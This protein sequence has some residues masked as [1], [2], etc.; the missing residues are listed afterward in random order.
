M[1]EEVDAVSHL[2]RMDWELI[3]HLPENLDVVDIVHEGGEASFVIIVPSVPR[4]HE[5]PDVF[6][7]GGT[8][9]L[10]KGLFIFASISSRAVDPTAI[11][12]DRSQ[13]IDLDGR[14]CHNYRLLVKQSPRAVQV[15]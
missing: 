10:E 7:G 8:Q 3:H 4:K 1:L 15:D 2:E 13:A 14:C 11:L 5:S 9:S 12:R 6:E